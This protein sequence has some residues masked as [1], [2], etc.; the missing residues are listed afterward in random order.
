MPFSLVALFCRLFWAMRDE[1]ER[2]GGL[3]VASRGLL[4]IFLKK[5]FLCNLFL[6]N[7]LR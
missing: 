1:R 2:A 7:F 4:Q 6:A 5:W 3:A